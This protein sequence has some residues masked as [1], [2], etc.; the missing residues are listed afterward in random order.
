MQVESIV[1]FEPEIDIISLIDKEIYNEIVKESEKGFN[2][3]K[4]LKERLPSKITYAQIRIALAKHKVTS[5][6]PS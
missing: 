5:Q 6:N 1:E 2:N 4:E 3:I